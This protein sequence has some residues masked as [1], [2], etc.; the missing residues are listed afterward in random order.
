MSFLPI[1]NKEENKSVAITSVFQDKEYTD[2]TL[3]I[4]HL[5]MFKYTNSF[6]L[7]QRSRN[8]DIL[9]SELFSELQKCKVQL[10]TDL[11]KFK[12]ANTDLSDKSY[13]TKFIN[14]EKNKLI[15]LF[16]TKYFPGSCNIQSNDIKSSDL[17][18]DPV[19]FFNSIKRLYNLFIEAAANQVGCHIINPDFKFQ[20]KDIK[21][22]EMQILP[23]NDNQ[24]CIRYAFYQAHEKKLEHWIFE[25]TSWN[26]FTKNSLPGNVLV[27]KMQNLGYKL[28]SQAQPRDIIFYM[29]AKDQVTHAGVMHDANTVYSK[30]GTLPQIVSHRINSVPSVYKNCYLLFR[31][32][33][34]N[35]YT[36]WTLDSSKFQAKY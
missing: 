10:E 11:A 2:R 29:D 23:P 1:S 32:A 34:A 19:E 25:E 26:P 13:F 9:M 28:V 15:T 24:T 20:Y 35:N 31:K 22:K 16:S 18:A 14:I 30:L 5:N 4:C 7:D 12:K 6:E 21:T 17:S 27:Q 33:R 36:K 3:E 8:L